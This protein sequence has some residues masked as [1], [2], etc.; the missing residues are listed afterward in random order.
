MSI[1]NYA[2][3][4]GDYFQQQERNNRGGFLNLGRRSSFAASRVGAAKSQGYANNFSDRLGLKA[5]RYVKEAETDTTEYTSGFNEFKMT[6]AMDD[7][8][9][10]SLIEG[11]AYSE[12]AIGFIGDSRSNKPAKSLKDYVQ[13]TNNRKAVLRRAQKSI[14]L[15][16]ESYKAKGASI[17][18]DDTGYSP[19][20]ENKNKFLADF[21][22]QITDRANKYAQEFGHNSFEDMFSGYGADN[23]SYSLGEVESRVNKRTGKVE[24]FQT[25]NR[26]NEG[27]GQRDIMDMIMADLTGMSYLDVGALNQWNSDY[28]EKGAYRRDR[29]SWSPYTNANAGY[30]TTK[31]IDGFNAEEWVS[32]LGGATNKYGGTASYG[33]DYTQEQLTGL[34]DFYGQSQLEAVQN[35]NNRAISESDSR[36]KITE[37]TRIGKLGAQKGIQ[38]VSNE[39]LGKSE[40]AIQMELRNLDEKFMK[41]IGAFN[42]VPKKR[43]V[44]SISFVEGRPE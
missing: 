15:A 11:A 26:T 40:A 19:L 16:R 21:D 42:T 36:K 1:F 34:R 13:K 17:T 44:P 43:K 6:D 9:K 20:E 35:A 30:G 33:K 18:F 27:F 24:E 7:R 28:I 5:G 4:E 29:N 14:G 39:M 31:I 23:Y 37:S 8:N 22:S 25:T 41:N 32:S 10:A 2:Y 38:K 12:E 3:G